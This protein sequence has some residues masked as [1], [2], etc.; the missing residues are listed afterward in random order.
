M[1]TFQAAVLSCRILALYVLFRALSPVSALPMA[2]SLIGNHTLNPSQ[3]LLEQQ[4]R[5]NL[6][7][8]LTYLL[9][10]PLCGLLAAFLWIKAGWLAR[11]IAE[12]AAADSAPTFVRGSDLQRI[13]LTV[14][15][16]LVLAFAIPE[17]ARA[18]AS[19]LM[20]AAEPDA[21][22]DTPRS[23]AENWALLLQFLVG[24]GLIFGAPAV[25]RSLDE[26]NTAET[27]VPTRTVKEQE[28]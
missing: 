21:A 23:I 8:L 19:G 18:I 2:F 13:L 22:I 20:A 26:L 24:I 1:T 10:L 7:F 28:A 27:K 4:Y 17:A 16:A 6:L 11:K 5:Q 9:P 12:T 3:G 14:I 15:G 25:S